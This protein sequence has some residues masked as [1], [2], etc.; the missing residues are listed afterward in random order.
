MERLRQK[1]IG[2]STAAKLYFLANTLIPICAIALWYVLPDPSSLL[3]AGV[4]LPALLLTVAGFLHWLGQ[5]LRRR[6]LAFGVKL[7][8]I[9]V[10]A[11][12]IPLCISMARNVVAGATG[13]PGQSFDL[14]VSLL[15]LVFI[16]FA[17]SVLAAAVALFTFFVVA[18]ALLIWDFV[19]NFVRPF[20]SLR[21]VRTANTEVQRRPSKDVSNHVSGF[22][23]TAM[24]FLAGCSFSVVLVCDPE[25]VRLLTY[26]L[27]FTQLEGY[28]G[29]E[30]GRAVKLLDNG[31]IAY[32]R[33][34]G[35]EVSI[36][37]SQW[38]FPGS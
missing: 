20:L 35:F 9:A 2:M 33:K 4:A 19:Y 10:Q 29:V 6:P 25:F 23:T 8:A 14:T 32:A 3:M 11:L 34:V 24:F 5:M 28:P 38:K 17:W 26:W 13:L 27:D 21:L 1:W 31:L 36:D 18:N 22:F 15:V 37:V 7:L 30:H 16:P 12:L